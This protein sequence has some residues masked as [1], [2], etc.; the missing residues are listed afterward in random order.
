MRRPILVAVVLAA[1]MILPATSAT[2]TARKD[3]CA[4]QLCTRL[5]PDTPSCHRFRDYRRVTRCYIVRA[6][7]HFRQPVGLALTVAYRESRFKWWVQNRAACDGRGH[8]A[9]GTFQFC[10]PTW[11]STIYA[12]RGHSPFSPRWSSLAAMWMWKHGGFHHWAL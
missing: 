9:Q 3:P 1:V 2:A 5:K 7:R 6:A 11:R 8:H 10:V 12:K 4:N